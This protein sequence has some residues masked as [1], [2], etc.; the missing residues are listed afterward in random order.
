MIDISVLHLR[1]S[2]QAREGSK[3]REIITWSTEHSRV[4]SH[5]GSQL[6]NSQVHWHQASVSYAAGERRLG[7]V[8][9]HHELSNVAVDAIGANDSICGGSGAVCKAQDNRLITTEIVLNLNQTFAH[10][11][12]IFGDSC[13][14]VVDEMGTVTGLQAG[15]ALL[16]M[17][18]LAGSGTMALH[19][20][21]VKLYCYIDMMTLMVSVVERNLRKRSSRRSSDEFPTY[22]PSH[23]S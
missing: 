7:F 13:D 2:E 3:I 14:E 9:A 21:R 15:G 4:L 23:F 12:A 17:N 8:F 11:Y 1:T 10:M 20:E 5:L 6:L 16:G 22:F 18:M 19:H